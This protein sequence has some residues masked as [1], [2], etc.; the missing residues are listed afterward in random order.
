[1]VLDIRIAKAAMEE[2]MAGR[3]QLPDQRLLSRYNV[4]ALAVPGC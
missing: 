4:G 1:L 2:N 3:E